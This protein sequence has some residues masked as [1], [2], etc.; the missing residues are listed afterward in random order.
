MVILAVC[1]LGHFFLAE[2][3]RHI[4]YR[5]YHSKSKLA[6]NWKE[7][8]REIRIDYFKK[9]YA[10]RRGKKAIS[11][12]LTWLRYKKRTDEFKVL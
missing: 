1:Q 12:S 6:G 4:Q 3:I 8:S 7:T 10:L 9:D 11:P 5:E 2:G